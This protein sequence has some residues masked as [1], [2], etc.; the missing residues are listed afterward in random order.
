MK[1]EPRWNP[2]VGDV[3]T[4]GYQTRTVTALLSRK[5]G[6]VWSLS[7]RVKDHKHNWEYLAFPTLAQWR[8]WADKAEVV[9]AVD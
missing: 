9:N 3:L 6:V 4:R 2:K 8:K 7:L 1:R 5:D